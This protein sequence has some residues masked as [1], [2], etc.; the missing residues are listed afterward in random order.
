MTAPQ[1]DLVICDK[2]DLAVWTHLGFV[3]RSIV[4]FT[5]A[6]H[7]RG[8]ELSATP[9]HDSREPHAVLWT[10]ERWA[11]KAI[12]YSIVSQDGVTHVIGAVDLVVLWAHRPSLLEYRHSFAGISVSISLGPDFWRKVEATRSEIPD[13][14]LF[15]AEDAAE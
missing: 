14:Q 3:G 13:F 11:E 7:W 8:D 2:S 6:M 4:G 15:R 9:W 10:G 12:G 1:F 5:L